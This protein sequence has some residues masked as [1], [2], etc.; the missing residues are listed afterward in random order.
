MQ[1]PVLTLTLLSSLFT[2]PV[3]A[4]TENKASLGTR[5]L[6]SSAVEFFTYDGFGQYQRDNLWYT[7]VA[8]VGDRIEI[9]GQ[10]GWDPKTGALKQ[11][12]EEIDQA[13]E[14]V[15]LTL[16]IAGGKGWSQVFKVITYVQ[17]PY[18]AN[19]TYMIHVVENMKKW[20]PDV[21]P[22]WTAVG[23]TDLGAGLV[24]DMKIEVEVVA[25]IGD[26]H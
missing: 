19:E 12:L 13:F 17:S 22:L 6:K 8:R 18:F 21:Q 25:Y 5:H 23:V 24:A 7:Q 11:D 3:S 14:N 15:E 10:G 16:R 2:L 26:K 9:S 4:S 1:I 20:L